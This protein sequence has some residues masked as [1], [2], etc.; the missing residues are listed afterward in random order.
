MAWSA[1]T[2]TKTIVGDTIWNE[3]EIQIWNGN[4]RPLAMDAIERGLVGVVINQGNGVATIDSEVTGY[5]ELHGKINFGKDASGQDIVPLNYLN[6]LGLDFHAFAQWTPAPIL[7]DDPDDPT[8]CLEPGN[9]Q[10]TM[11]GQRVAV[12]ATLYDAN[13]NLVQFKNVPITFYVSASGDSTVT[14]RFVDANGVEQHANVAPNTYGEFTV[15]SN[16]NGQGFISISAPQ[17]AAAIVQAQAPGYTVELKDGPVGNQQILNENG[18]TQINFGQASLWYIPEDND[19]EATQGPISMTKAIVGNRQIFGIIS[20]VEWPTEDFGTLQYQENCDTDPLTGSVPNL[21]GGTI[22]IY[23]NLAD[24]DVD[25]NDMPLTVT[26]SEPNKFTVVKVDPTTSTGDNPTDP[27]GNRPG[28]QHWYA[29]SSVTGYQYISVTV[30]GLQPWSSMYLTLPNGAVINNPGEGIPTGLNVLN[31]SVQWL[32]RGAIAQLITPATVNVSVS[33]GTTPVTVKVTDG[34]N[35]IPD[36]TVTFSLNYMTTGTAVIDPDVDPSALPRVE[37][38]KTDADGLATINVVGGELGEVDQVAITV[39]NEAT[40]TDVKF[41]DGTYTGSQVINWTEPVNPGIS[42]SAVTVTQQ[43]ADPI[44]GAP[45]QGSISYTATLLNVGL[46]DSVTVDGV[47][48]TKAALYTGVTFTDVNELATLINN[49]PSVNAVASSSGSTYTVTITAAEP[50]TAGNSIGLA[51]NDT[52]ASA[53]PVVVPMSGGTDPVD[54]IYE[55]AEVTIIGTAAANGNITVT[56]DGTPYLVAVAAGDTAEQV[57][58]KIAAAL[59]VP[60]YTVTSAG[61]V[62]TFTATVPGNVTD[63]TVTIS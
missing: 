46:G 23:C 17:A 58:A 63:L 32:A 52:G 51:F 9:Q 4:V 36:Q 30:S 45:A 26:T 10:Y 53:S 19:F 13:G 35:P 43:G 16:V 47:T 49:L 50:G 8:T 3:N 5:T 61:D 62:V 15:N 29:V 21:S 34:V 39:R 22:N 18:L 59:S 7:P 56:V 25:V 38:V 55:T 41:A 12:E 57:A 44:P 42:A 24:V 27:A 48:F 60:G 14:A 37:K 31:I 40:G 33:E 28:I 1:A 11:A 2:R 54:G 20:E 6:T